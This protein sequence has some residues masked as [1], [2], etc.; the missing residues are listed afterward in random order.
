MRTAGWVD[1]GGTGGRRGSPGPGSGGKLGRARTAC[2][3]PAETR[4]AMPTPGPVKFE[5]QVRPI[6]EDRCQLCLSGVN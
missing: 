6:L 1:R 4:S 5:K 3:A 2:A